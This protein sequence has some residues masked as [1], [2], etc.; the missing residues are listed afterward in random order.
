MHG[1]FEVWL[2][3]ECGS[4]LYFPKAFRQSTRFSQRKSGNMSPYFHG[5]N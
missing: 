2:L 4:N 5:G 3:N 1:G